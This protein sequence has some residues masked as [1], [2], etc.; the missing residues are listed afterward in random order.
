MWLSIGTNLLF[1]LIRDAMSVPVLPV[2]PIF[3]SAVSK[4]LTAGTNARHALDSFDTGVLL[5]MVERA[6]VHM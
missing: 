5:L 6:E 1:T 3:F 2:K 4:V